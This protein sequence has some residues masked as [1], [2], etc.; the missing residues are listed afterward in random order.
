MQLVNLMNS[1]LTKKIII[2]AVVIIVLVVAVYVI[3]QNEELSN[4]KL[5]LITPTVS[6]TQAERGQYVSLVT[7]NAVPTDTIEISSCS[8]NPIDSSVVKGDEITIINNDA[9]S[10]KISFTPD[11]SFV[12]GTSSSIM[13]KADFGKTAGVY[14]FQ[15]DSSTS[16]IGVVLVK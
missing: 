1:K 12:V 9:V 10:H 13:I 3:Y 8:P 4:M 7:K 15:C 2:A 11:H 5:T 6:S 16:T 14:P